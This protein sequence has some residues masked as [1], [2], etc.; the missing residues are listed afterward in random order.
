MTEIL[1]ARGKTMNPQGRKII[2]VAGKT[3]IF[4][5]R[6]PR[7]DSGGGE[8]SRYIAYCRDMVVS[9]LDLESDPCIVPV[10]P[11]DAKKT[12]TSREG[13]A[14]LRHC[15]DCSPILRFEVDVVADERHVGV[16]WSEWNG[17]EWSG[18]E[19]S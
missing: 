19:W 15:K 3:S 9:C 10:C 7:T 11:R 13:V 14:I 2:V 18:V 5:A 17:V 12:R 4:F 16:E 1:Q 6:I 8:P